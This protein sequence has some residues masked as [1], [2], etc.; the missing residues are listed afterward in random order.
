MSNTL[1]G[2]R[3]LFSLRRGEK[4][5][6]VYQGTGA[7]TDNFSKGVRNDIG[8]DTEAAMKKV[9]GLMVLATDFVEQG[10][11]QVKVVAPGKKLLAMA[12]NVYGKTDVDV[13]L[14]PFA[15]AMWLFRQ[16]YEGATP[17]EVGDIMKWI[18]AAMVEV[19]D[20]YAPVPDA[21]EQQPEPTPVDEPEKCKN[22]PADIKAVCIEAREVLGIE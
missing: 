19:V 22:C 3:S 4:P 10:I 13:T 6:L 1:R 5:E 8:D 12:D 18:D 2:L 16:G 7:S 9:G 15:V 14:D 17:A 11:F 21:P 20:R